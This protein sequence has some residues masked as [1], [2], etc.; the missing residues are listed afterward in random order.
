M[1]SDVSLRMSQKQVWCTDEV[2]LSNKT[3][4]VIWEELV[5]WIFSVSIS[6]HL[7]LKWYVYLSF[8]FRMNVIIISKFFCLGTMRLCLHAEQ[9]LWIPPAGTTEWVYSTTTRCSVMRPVC[10]F[11]VLMWFLK[12][13]THEQVGQELS[14]QARCPFE[15]GQSNVGLF[16]GETH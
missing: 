16:A 5:G 4:S 12:S 13:S 14:G 11:D 7:L 9:T 8:S 3:H 15:S 2:A 6:T 10:W 1:F